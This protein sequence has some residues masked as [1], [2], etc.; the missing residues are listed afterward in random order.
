MKMLFVLGYSLSE[1]NDATPILRERLNKTIEIA[2]I[3]K[4][5]LVIVVMG[6][7]PN[8]HPEKNQARFMKGWLIENGVREDS[9]ITEE[10][11]TNTAEQILYIYDETQKDANEID[12]VIIVA[13]EGGFQE[14]VKLFTDNILPANLN[15]RI[16]GASIPKDIE[17]HEYIQFTDGERSRIEALKKAQEALAPDVNLVDELRRMIKT[18]RRGD[19]D[20]FERVNYPLA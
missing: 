5:N 7:Y 12:E 1:T 16:I 10:K 8:G 20:P 13:T 17:K 18:F 19:T 11:S 14:R 4:K 6:G 15:V 9:I 3:E 2:N